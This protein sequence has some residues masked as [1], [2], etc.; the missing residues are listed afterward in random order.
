MLEH[1]FHPFV[2]LAFDQ[3]DETSLNPGLVN[4]LLR[5]CSDH[6]RHLKIPKFL[7]D[8]DPSE[9]DDESFSANPRLETLTMDWTDLQGPRAWH[10]Y[11]MSIASDLLQGIQ[12]NPNFQRLNLRFDVPKYPNQDLTH[13]FLF[14]ANGNLTQLLTQVIPNHPS[15]KELTVEVKLHPSAICDEMPIRPRLRGTPGCIHNFISSSKSFP[16]SLSHVSFT[17]EWIDPSSKLASKAEISLALWD[18]HITPRLAMN[19]LFHQSQAEQRHEA[20]T[21]AF[22]KKAAQRIKRA[23]VQPAASLLALQIR[24]INEGILYRKTSER[25]PHDTNTTNASVISALLRLATEELG[26]V[27]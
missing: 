2:R 6:I 12:H 26:P 8:Y 4:Y 5:H 21:W 23:G 18:S 27:S 22:S 14:C 19:W 24:A 3:I 17:S 9:N 15:F 7:V 25:L 1:P 11:N 13:R 10:R 20:P 16:N